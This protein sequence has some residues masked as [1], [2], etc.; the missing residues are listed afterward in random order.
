MSCLKELRGFYD[1]GHVIHCR[2][3][4]N[5]I[6]LLD[7]VQDSI[8]ERS[9]RLRMASELNSIHRGPNGEITLQWIRMQL[10]RMTMSAQSWFVL[11][12]AGALIL[13]PSFYGLIFSQRCIYWYKCRSYIYCNRVALRHKNG[14]LLG[15]LVAEPA[16]L[17]LG[18]WRRRECLQLMAC[19]EH[20]IYG[21]MDSI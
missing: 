17:L 15:W 9:R 1:D 13:Q 19:L 6:F 11:S 18:N 2:R 7:W 21:E 5:I 4:Y 8:L 16:I 12:L 3:W 14:V 10:I 20:V